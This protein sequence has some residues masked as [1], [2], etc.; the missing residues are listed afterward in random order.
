MYPFI[1]I[2]HFDC[3]CLTLT[4][5]WAW[6]DKLMLFH[7]LFSNSILNLCHAH[8]LR[9]NCTHF[10]VKTQIFMNKS[11]FF[12]FWV[13]RWIFWR[14]VYLRKLFCSSI[15]TFWC[16]TH[17]CVWKLTRPHISIFEFQP[18]ASKNGSLH[19]VKMVEKRWNFFGGV[20]RPKPSR[21]TTKTMT[22]P[23]FPKSEPP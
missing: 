17:V 12:N 9:K 23:T 19:I 11:V 21:K 22:I 13:W 5:Y 7:Y 1:F 4:V 3:I 15:R 2:V 6:N 16:A 20:S 8:Q 18:F 14:H 10:Y